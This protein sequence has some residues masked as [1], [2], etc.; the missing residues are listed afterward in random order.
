MN[1]VELLEAYHLFENFKSAQAEFSQVA[2]GNEVDQVIQT[3]RKRQD[4]ISS[5]RQKDINYWRKQG[6]DEFKKFVIQ[7]D[8]HHDSKKARRAKVKSASNEILTI[9][10]TENSHLFIPLS[11][12]ASCFY[13][14]GTTFC[15]STRDGDNMFYHYTI[16]DQY[17]VN[18]LIHDDEIYVMVLDPVTGRVIECQDKENNNSFPPNTF[19]EY[20]GVS[21]DQLKDFIDKNLDTIFGSIENKYENE[22]LRKI[23]KVVQHVKSGKEIDEDFLF[24]NVLDLEKRIPEIESQV[25]RLG[26]KMVYVY[27]VNNVQGRWPEAERVVASNSRYAYAYAHRVIDGK[28]ELGEPAIAKNISTSLSYAE[29]IGERFVAGE[30]LI[31]KDL[32]YA[33][34]Y[35]ELGPEY[36]KAMK[37]L[38]AF[39]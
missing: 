22:N 20:A 21:L 32:E 35:A 36:E 24:D 33:R 16:K 34:A 10:R 14:Q 31:A 25:M 37:D 17:V 2:D 26:P 23:E 11:K 19:L 18:F 28:W 27:A 39:G 13:G 4:R 38:G 6:W 29:L 3:F 8:Q 30:P 15:I 5:A 7:I 1:I 12:E 9:K